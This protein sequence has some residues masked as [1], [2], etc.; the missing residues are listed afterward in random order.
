MDPNATLR[1]IDEFIE[2]RSTS[3]EVDESVENLREWL[4]KGGFEPDWKRYPLGTAYYHARMVQRAKHISGLGLRKLPSLPDGMIIVEEYAAGR[5]IAYPEGDPERTHFG[6]SHQEALG[7]L[8]YWTNYLSDR[9]RYE[10]LNTEPPKVP[11]LRKD[12]TEAEHV[13]SEGDGFPQSVSQRPRRD[14]FPQSIDI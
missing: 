3:N 9:V 14:G 8:I 2:A 12:T 10:P 7:E 5:W 4:A 11:N 1:M 6:N 13:S